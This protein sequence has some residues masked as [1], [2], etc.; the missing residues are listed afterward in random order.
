MGVYDYHHDSGKSDRPGMPTLY[1]KRP[2]VT[3]GNP[4]KAYV[5][6]VA[7]FSADGRL[8]PLQIIWEDG[9]RYSIDKI[10]QMDRRASLRAGGA[11]IRYQCRVCGSPVSLYYEENGMWFVER[12]IPREAEKTEGNAQG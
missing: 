10:L 3:K 6:V 12:K 1:E 11:G 5:E 2:E 9:R 8:R 7:D 4:Y